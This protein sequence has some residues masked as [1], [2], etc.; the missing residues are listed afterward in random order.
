MKEFLVQGPN[1]E[2]NLKESF[3]RHLI[4]PIWSSQITFTL[5]EGAL[6]IFWLSGVE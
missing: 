3:H 2:S 4:T 6:L 1:D 5:T